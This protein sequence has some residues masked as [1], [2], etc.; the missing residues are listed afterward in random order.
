MKQLHSLPKLVTV[1]TLLLFVTTAIG[2]GN[3]IVG[4]LYNLA[5]YG[6]SNGISA[7]SVGTTS[8]NLGD[9]PVPWVSST[10][11]H[12]T[13][14]LN[15]YRLENG[16]FEQVGMSWLKHGFLALSGSV[17]TPCQGPGGSQLDP[18]CSD[19]YSASLNGSQSNLGPR[20][21][22]NAS[23]GYF[24]YPPANPSYATTIGRRIQ[25]N[26]SDLT[27]SASTRYF[28]EGHY[29]SSYD[30]SVNNDEDNASYREVDVSGSGSNYSIAFSSGSST[31]RQNPAIQAWA[32]IDPAVTISYVDIPGDGRF[33]VAYK[34][35]PIGGGNYHWEFAVHN[36]N[37]HDSG[38][39]FSV[40]LP[41]GAVVSNVGFHGIAHHSNDGEGGG[42]YSS[43]NWTSSVN[44]S[45]VT[46]QTSTFAQDP[47]AN[48]LRWSTLY[49]FRFDCNMAPT[50]IVSATIGL[51]RSGGALNVPPVMDI[52]QANTPD[53]ALRVSG[54]MSANNYPPAD[55]YN[56]P[57]FVSLAAGQ[58]LTMDFAS[59]PN[60]VFFLLNGPLNRNNAVFPL[61]GSLDIGNGGATNNFGDLAVLL[62]GANGTSF[63]DTLARVG[64]SG[65]QSI[66]VPIGVG[67]SAGLLGTFQCAMFDQTNTATLKFS[68]ATEITI[69]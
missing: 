4:D 46:W 22:V 19:P 42:V 14:A 62:D 56:G 27:S 21:E 2:Q 40:P 28:V 57:F 65:Y 48:A 5:N 67:L 20:G 43:A 37:S 24:P 3:I 63:L 59:N 1:L 60:Y 58:Q 13:I 23:N 49:N 52:G 12:P 55:G 66:S 15:M 16:Q 9:Q 47:L 10:N 61:F 31:E 18:G 50:G 44:N 38:R 32:T 34:V 11:N 51:F 69:Q 6:S 30:S 8:C 33:T 35:T 68:A 64:S 7:F 17:C 54:A 26:N 39:S 36:L 29:V 53:A 41:A 45:A 25:V